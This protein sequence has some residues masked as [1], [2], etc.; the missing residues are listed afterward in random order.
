MRVV[1]ANLLVPEALPP[2]WKLGPLM[3]LVE[4]I[5]EANNK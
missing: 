3:A 4:K 2:R 1:E 5:L